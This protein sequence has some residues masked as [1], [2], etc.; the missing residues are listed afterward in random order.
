[1]HTEKQV[2]DTP[3]RMFQQLE[4]GRAQQFRFVDN[5]G[6]V[7]MHKSNTQKEN[8]VHYL[9]FDNRNDVYQRNF[10][11]IHTGIRNKKTKRQLNNRLLPIQCTLIYNKRTYNDITTLQN[12]QQKISEEFIIRVNPEKFTGAPSAKKEAAERRKKELW[13]LFIKLIADPN[14][15]ATVSEHKDLYQAILV[16][17]NALRT[18]DNPV[19]KIDDPKIEKYIQ[20]GR[21]FPTNNVVDIIK[22]AKS[23]Y[24]EVARGFSYELSLAVSALEQDTQSYVQMG[25]IQNFRTAPAPVREAVSSN[26]EQPELIFS[27][28]RIGADVVVWQPANQ[29]NTKLD[30]LT[31]GAD[32]VQA[33]C[34][35]FDSACKL[36]KQA[37]NQLAGT[38]AS[39]QA[40]AASDKECTL[41][42]QNYMGSIFISII[43]DI[44]DIKTLERH[45]LECIDNESVHSVVIEAKDGTK[46]FYP[47]GGCVIRR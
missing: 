13:E 5:R 38:A 4:K 43:D 14:Y 26:K 37:K 41:I 31:Y 23:S 35:K 34:C 36:M 11:L 3:S 18:N 16:Y 15:S 42:D 10:D 17:E 30:P 32:F 12:D 21:L 47:P 40:V 9:S 7:P 28:K 8:T 45:A 39:G 44:K 6:N 33:K 46:Y 25:A 19:Q 22:R 2:K 20:E 27:N 24:V 1:M 29:I